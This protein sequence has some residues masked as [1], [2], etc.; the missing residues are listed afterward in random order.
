MIKRRPT[1]PVYVGGV[2]V[3]GDA[4]ITVQSMTKTDTRDVA[5]HGSADPRAGGGGV[6]HHTL[7]RSGHGGCHRDG[8]DQEA[9]QHSADRRHPLPLPAGPE[10]PGRRRGLP[11]AEPGQPAQ[12]GPGAG[13][14]GSLQG[15][16]CANPH[17][18]ELRQPAAGGRH[19]AD[20][21]FLAAHGF[22]QQA[23]QGGRGQR[24]R[25]QRGRPHGGHGAVGDQ[26]AG[27][28]GL[29]PD[30]D[31]DEGLRCADDRRGLRTAGG[32]GALPAAPGHHGGRDQDLRVHPHL[33]WPGRAAVPGASGIRSAFR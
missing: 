17:R 6:R 9:D 16:E 12:R 3:G 18:R 5:G 14:G 31:L 33:R 24:G 29:R 4:E 30:Q 32:D 8:R 26:P 13:S 15:A 25:L 1:K 11:A 22:G 28:A 20:Q 10:V 21:G 2:K 23:A 27:R 19:R 7:R